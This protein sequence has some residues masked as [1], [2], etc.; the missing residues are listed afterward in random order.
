MPRLRALKLGQVIR[1]EGPQGHQSKAGT[2][3]MGGL[4]V[5]PVS[6]SGYDEQSGYHS[7]QFLSVLRVG[8]GG[9]EVV[10]EIHTTEPA[11]RAVRIGDVLYAVGDTSVTAY[12]LSDLSEIGSTAAAPAVV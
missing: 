1:T 6:G 11:L 4:L 5:V 7:D 10:G 2:P 12:R 8:P 9:I 3:T